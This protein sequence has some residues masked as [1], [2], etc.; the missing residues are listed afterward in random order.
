MTMML[1]RSKEKLS[2][3]PNAEQALINLQQEYD[4]LI[5]KINHFYQV[6]KQL[7][8]TKRELVLAEIEK[9]DLM[10]QY[11]ELQDHLEVQRHR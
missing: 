8:T 5:K 4:L 10:T 6:R 2:T 1:K 9:S 11:K 3:H 7:L